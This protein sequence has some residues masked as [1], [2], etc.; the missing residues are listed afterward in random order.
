MKARSIPTLSTAFGKAILPPTYGMTACQST[1]FQARLD[2]LAQIGL[3]YP[4]H[5]NFIA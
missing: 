5:I 1:I 2:I 4:C 3:P